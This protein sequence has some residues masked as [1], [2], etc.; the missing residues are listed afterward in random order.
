[1]G[2]DGRTGARPLF[3]CGTRSGENRMRDGIGCG[4]WWTGTVE[5]E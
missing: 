3:K 2:G 1:M 5:Y 4:G